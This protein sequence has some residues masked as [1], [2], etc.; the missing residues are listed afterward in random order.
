[1]TSKICE[2]TNFVSNLLAYSISVASQ[3]IFSCLCLL[4]LIVYIVML[5]N[6]VEPHSSRTLRCEVF[7]RIGVSTV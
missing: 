4:L 1:M 7:K 2:C 5:L 3:C 6:I